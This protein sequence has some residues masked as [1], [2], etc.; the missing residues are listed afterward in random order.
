MAFTKGP[1]GP[2]KPGP[3]GPRKGKPTDTSKPPRRGPVKSGGRF[4]RDD[5]QGRQDSRY[6]GGQRQ[7]SRDSRDNRQG[8]QGRQDSR[9]GGDRRQDSRD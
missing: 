7:D 2:R 4:A 3:G 1:K 8:G 9:Y 5:R 6:G